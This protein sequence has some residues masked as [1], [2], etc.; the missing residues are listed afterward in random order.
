[1]PEIVIMKEIR[2]KNED[3]AKANRERFAEDHV[4]VVNVMGA[5]GAGKTSLIMALCRA[6]KKTGIKCSV[7]EGDLYSTIDTDS[8]ISAG[9]DSLQINTEGECHIDAAVIR[10]GYDRLKFADGVLFIENV[11]NLICPAEFDLGEDIRLIAA[12]VP[13]GDDKPYK[14]V[15]MY[16]YVDAV[17]LTKCDLKEAVGFDTDHFTRGLRA[18]NDAPVFETSA[19]NKEEACGMDPVAGFIADRY[20]ALG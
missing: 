12:S 14:Y 17:V 11:G 8:F 16:S 15:P 7:I 4:L 13:E 9:F 19:R 10:Q 1:M 5:P 3:H 6:L 18:L 20:R 2:G